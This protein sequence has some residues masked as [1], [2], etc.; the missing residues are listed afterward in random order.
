MS[1]EQLTVVVPVLNEERHL[2]SLTR[3]LN[4]LCCPVIVVDGGS[5]D[6]TY[7]KLRDLTAPHIT[8]D[9]TV[10]G[11]GLQ[12]NFGASMART[13]LLL[14]LH[15]DTLLPPEGASL[16]AEVLTNSSSTW[17]RFDISFDE[18]AIPLRTIAWFMNWRSALTGICTG[19]QAIFTTAKTFELVG[20]F[21]QIPLMEDIEISKQLKKIGK[22]A[23]VRVPVITA[24]RRW[25]TNGVARTMLTMWWLRFRYWYGASPDLLAEYYKHAR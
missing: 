8:V 14:F 15:A 16:A 21:K 6:R 4:S 22:P 18:S 25:R 9:R 12:M 5:T 23:R 10:R 2:E 13:P 24:A 20:R 3:H 1:T 17:G 7:A 19:D 11:R